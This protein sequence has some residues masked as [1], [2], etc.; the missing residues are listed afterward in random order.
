MRSCCPSALCVII[1][2]CEALLGFRFLP[3]QTL[4][5]LLVAEVILIIIIS[6][7]LKG[8]GKFDP[9]FLVSLFYYQG[10]VSF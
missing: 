5:Q 2:V 3:I 10:F 4:K 7:S 9:S 6:H 1:I 8:K